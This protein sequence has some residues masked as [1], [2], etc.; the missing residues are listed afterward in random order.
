MDNHITLTIRKFFHDLLTEPDNETYCI[1]KT[2]SAVGGLSFIG[3]GLTHV[4]INHNF[5]FVGFGTGMGAIVGAAG[6][7]AGIKKDTPIK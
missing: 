5:D 2:L 4:I 7:G 6:I 3:L 1:I